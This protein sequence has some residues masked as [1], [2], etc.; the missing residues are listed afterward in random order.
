MRNRITKY[1]PIFQKSRV[2]QPYSENRV[3]F[4]KVKNPLPALQKLT[5]TIILAKKNQ[6]MPDI[7]RIGNGLCKAVIQHAVT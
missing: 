6:T 2:F 3:F 4:L 1:L 5:K 7:R